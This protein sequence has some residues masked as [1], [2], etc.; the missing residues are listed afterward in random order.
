MFGRNRL[1]DNEDD[2]EEEVTESN[3]GA[4]VLKRALRAA[5]VDVATD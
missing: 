5:E 4:G 3:G 1:G 2:E